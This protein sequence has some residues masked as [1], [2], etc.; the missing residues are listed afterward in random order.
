MIDPNS[1][2]DRELKVAE[3]FFALSRTATSPFTRD[4][5][6]RV[7]ERYLSPHGGLKD[8]ARPPARDL[9]GAR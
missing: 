3:E 4:Y 8:R 7:A 6:R 1:R 9:I 5:C 2:H